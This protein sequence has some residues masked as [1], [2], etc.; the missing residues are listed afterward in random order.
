MSDLEQWLVGRPDVVCKMARRYPPGTA[1]RIHGT[2]VW[3]VSYNE[4]GG[5]SVSE[6]D[7]GVD[8]ETAVATRQPVC[9]CCVKNLDAL[10][11]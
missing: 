3:V 6:T 7:P 10:R 1:F 5:V 11:I 9:G 4:D 2:V 8:Y